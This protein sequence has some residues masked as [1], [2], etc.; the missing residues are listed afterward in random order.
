MI[1]ITDLEDNR[2]YVVNQWISSAEEDIRLA[3][4]CLNTMYPP[5]LNKCC[6]HYQQ[7]AEIYLKAMLAVI[8]KEIEKT[9]ELESLLDCLSDSYDIPKNFWDFAEFLSPFAVCT[10]YPNERMVDLSLVNNIK[11]KSEMICEWAKEQIEVKK[12]EIEEKEKKKS[13]SKSSRFS[14]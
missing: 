7:A 4:H 6:F 9:H 2:W 8:D 11:Y 13:K 12:I 14:R 5:P 3:D 10:R 1:Q